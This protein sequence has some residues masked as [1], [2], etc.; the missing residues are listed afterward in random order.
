M[1]RWLQ[2]GHRRAFD[3][4]PVV[5]AAMIGLMTTLLPCGWLYAFVVTAAGTASPWLG[6]VAMA[7]FWL[8][9]LPMMV[10]LGATIRGVTGSLGRRLPAL[11]CV[12]LMGM[13]LFTLVHRARLDPVA[14]AGRISSM[15][16]Q[17]TQDQDKLP[18]CKTSSH[19]H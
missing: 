19:E 13:G 2:A 16:L 7:V 11:T 10:A 5:R 4:P 18:C 9:T 1:Q 15:S 8:G 6:A 3:R 12:A 17:E 14:L